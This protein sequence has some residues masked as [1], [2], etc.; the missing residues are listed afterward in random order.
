MG[1]GLRRALP[2]ALTLALAASVAAPRTDPPSLDDLAALADDGSFETLAD[3]DP[4]PAF[5]EPET[6]IEGQLVIEGVPEIPRTLESVV[7]RYRDVSS[8]P[9]VGWGHD[10]ML[11]TARFDGATQIVRLAAPRGAMTPLTSGKGAAERITPS[12][13]GDAIVFTRDQNGDELHQG[14]F[15]DFRA[16]I[17][18]S[19]TEP[20][21]RNFAF[22]WS[23]DGSR[24]VWCRMK[25][26]DADSD[27]LITDPRRPGAPRVV[28]KGRGK[29]V[30][31]D[32]SPDGETVLVGRYISI[33]RA[34]RFLLNVETGDLKQIAPGKRVRWRGGEFTPDGKHFLAT[35]DDRSQFQRLALVDAATGKAEI[36]TGDVDW[37]V[38]DFDLSPDGRTAAYVVN[39]GGVSRIRLL[40]LETRTAG[41]GPELPAGVVSRLA[42]SPDSAR[43]GFTLSAA[44]RPSEAWAFDI[45]R[46]ELT[47]WTRGDVGGLDT[48]GFVAPELV[49]F[50]SFDGRMIPTFVYLPDQP[51]DGPMPVIV[52]IHGGPEGQARPTF[53]SSLQFW[54]NEL[55]VAVITPNVRGSSGYGKTYVALDNGF[56]R[57]DAVRDIGALFDWIEDDPRLDASRV[58]VY[59]GSYGGYMSLA[60]AVNYADRIVGAINIVGMSNIATFLDNTATYRRSRRRLEYGDERDPDMREF[61]EAIA[62]ANN[63]DKITAPLFVIHGQNDPRVP[64]SEAEQ[65]RDAVRANGGDAWYLLAKDE[66]HGFSKRANREFRLAA[67]TLFLTEVLSIE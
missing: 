57:I 54:V 10:G 42:F 30:P 61:L 49:A 41:D 44:T 13:R 38:E 65:I 20:G 26:G 17:E 12:P 8:A 32:W 66:G 35:T 59:G 4:V 11:A 1:M 33:T 2:V 58:A 7:K 24:V 25:E 28:L 51:R 27:I 15:I 52:D 48:D 14:W 22:T 46:G 50:R 16:G 63:A 40:D 60:S 19:F 34:K 3:D 21:A 23:R 43:L 62:P 5:D 53:S 55:G 47:A 39:A 6:R 56:N 64:A 45:G 67:E 9:F 37:D 36:L 31:L 18:R 29:M